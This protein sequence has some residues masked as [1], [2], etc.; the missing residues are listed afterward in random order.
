MRNDLSD[1]FLRDLVEAT[2][3]QLGHSALDGLAG[4]LLASVVPTAALFSQIIAQVVDFY[5]DTD[6]AEQIAHLAEQRANAQIMPLIFEALREFY[7]MTVREKKLN[8]ELRSESSR[9]FQKKKCEGGVLICEQ[10]SSVLLKAQSSAEFACTAVAERQQVLASIIDATR[11]VGHQFRYIFSRF[12]RY[13]RPQPLGIPKPL[14]MRGP[15]WTLSVSLAWIVEG[16]FM[17]K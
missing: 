3:S 12:N 6:K 13:C 14:T 5:I 17:L 4:S 9:E 8:E 2:G 16:K 10:L 1:G 15:Q 7:L 11:D